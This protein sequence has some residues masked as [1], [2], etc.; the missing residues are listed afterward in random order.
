MRASVKQSRRRGGK[1]WDAPQIAAAPRPTLSIVY[2]LR[3]THVLPAEPTIDL[4]LLAHWSELL[5]CSRCWGRGIRRNVP[6]LISPR[7]KPRTLCR[8]C[9]EQRAT[10]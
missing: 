8:G 7:H 2:G 1:M 9:R 6:Q 10:H 3:T 4:R 5:L